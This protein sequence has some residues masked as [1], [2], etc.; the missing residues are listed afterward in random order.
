MVSTTLTGK[1]PSL[2]MASLSIRTASSPTTPVQ[3]NDLVQETR[4]PT[5]RPRWVI[6]KEKVKPNGKDPK[7]EIQS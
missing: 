1:C 7:S 3:L 5:F 6:G 2:W 4:I